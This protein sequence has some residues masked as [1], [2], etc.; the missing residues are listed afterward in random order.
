MHRGNAHK[1]YI[2]TSS[3]LFSRFVISFSLFLCS[4]SFRLIFYFQFWL[5]S[6]LFLL[7]L[8]FFCREY[9]IRSFCSFQSKWTK[10]FG[11][12]TVHSKNRIPTSSKI[13]H[14]TFAQPKYERKKTNIKKYEPKTEQQFCH[15]NRTMR[16]P[17]PGETLR[18]LFPS[19][20]FFLCCYCIVRFEKCIVR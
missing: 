19:S 7:L 10:R 6:V 12:F 18:I 15:S 1:Y 11:E 2:Y 8:F 20:A 9:L 13:R 17:M 14:L 3:L 16:I 5:D 4:C